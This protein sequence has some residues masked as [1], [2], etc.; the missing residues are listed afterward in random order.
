MPHIDTHALGE[1]MLSAIKTPLQQHWNAVRPFAQTEMQKLALTALQIEVGQKDGSL[2]HHQAEILLQMQ[3]N[4][5]AAVLT[6]IET[7][8]M[9]A[10][11]NAINAALG[12][13]KNAVN[14]AVGFAFL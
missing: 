13:L 1:Q 12:V 10:A 5:T 11:Q 7:I 2:N 4:A 9:I 6:S 14:T 3:A 8:G